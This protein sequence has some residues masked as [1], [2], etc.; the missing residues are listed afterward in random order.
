MLRE[1]VEYING[2]QPLSLD[3]ARIDTSVDPLGVNDR[4][5]FASSLNGATITLT[6][7]E[8]SISDAV[9]IDASMLAL[10]LTIDASGNDPTGNGPTDVAGDGSSVFSIN[11]ASGA[12]T[13]RHLKMTGAAAALAA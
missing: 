4:I 9:T 3:L 12:A 6:E 8:L 5:V 13:L 10:G 7:G 2:T 1:A 11:L